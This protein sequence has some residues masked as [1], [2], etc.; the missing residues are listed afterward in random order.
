[1]DGMEEMGTKGTISTEGREHLLQLL[2]K[3][4]QT[5]YAAMLKRIELVHQLMESPVNYPCVREEIRRLDDE[6][7]E[8]NHLSQRIKSLNPDKPQHDEEIFILQVDEKIFG[9][10][11]T[12]LAWLR[13]LDHLKTAN[14]SRRSKS[15]KSS[16]SS[17][18]SRTS[19]S[20]STKELLNLH[21]IRYV[22]KA[23]K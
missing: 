14:L 9:A 22:D 10:K 19:S 3:N 21:R 20:K 17:K 12:A 13:N 18:S 16:K 7:E 23:A 1:M 4:G 2:K 11:T 6:L 5:V 15:Y 8:F